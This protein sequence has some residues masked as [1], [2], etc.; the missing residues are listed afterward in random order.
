MTPAHEASLEIA[1]GFLACADRTLW[2][3]ASGTAILSDLHL[4]YEGRLRRAGTAM[5]DFALDK[6]LEAWRG[7]LKR[8][9]RR[10]IIAGDIFHEAVPG[11]EALGQWNALVAALG[12]ALAGP[13]P[14]RCKV[15]VLPGNHDP[16]LSELARIVGG[17]P[18]AV[19]PLADVGGWTVCHGDVWPA[20]PSGLPGCGDGLAERKGL[21]VGH[22][23]PAVVLGDGVQ[24]EKMICFAY[25]QPPGKLPFIVLP[26]FSPAPLGSNLLTAG[27]WILNTAAPPARDVTIF[28]IV[29]E[30]VLDFGRLDRICG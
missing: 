12:N 13:A 26:P 24:R 11:A 17:G 5:P 3:P 10:I 20:E 22:Q 8:R 9:P 14:R 30:Q 25:C 15:A 7:V 27:Q 19:A 28:G 29:G 6:L 2:H 23:H 4:G 18:V 16:P 1:E 21:V